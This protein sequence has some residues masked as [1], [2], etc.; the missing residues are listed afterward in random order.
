MLEDLKRG[1][2]AS[3]RNA[4]RVPNC[5]SARAERAAPRIDLP[6]TEQRHLAGDL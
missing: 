4:R 3:G 2:R 5:R 6:M 1:R